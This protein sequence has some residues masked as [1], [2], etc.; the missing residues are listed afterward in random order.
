MFALF[1]TVMFTLVFIG[2]SFDAGRIRWDVLPV[3]GVSVAFLWFAVSRKTVQ[4]DDQWLYVSVFGRVAEIPLDQI[5]AVTESIGMNV[6]SRSVSVQFRCDTPFGRSITF[7]P[8]FMF[9]RE[10]HPIVS[11]LLAHGQQREQSGNA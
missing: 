1:F 3:A 9:T 11:E 2:A 6:N 10:P 7:S 4:M 5:A 8:T